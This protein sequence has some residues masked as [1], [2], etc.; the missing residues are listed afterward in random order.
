MFYQQETQAMTCA[1]T[2]F[3]SEVTSEIREGAKA[4]DH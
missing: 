4:E 1:T 2:I 3:Q